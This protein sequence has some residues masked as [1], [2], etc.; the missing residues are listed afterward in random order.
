MRRNMT[1][2]A[3]LLSLFV[4][5]HALYSRDWAACPEDIGCCP[6]VKAPENAAQRANPPQVG[7]PYGNDR[8]TRPYLAPFAHESRYQFGQ[9]FTFGY[10]AVESIPERKKSRHNRQ[11]RLSR[12]ER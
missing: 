1:Y 6:T 8:S 12:Q 5:T 2:V 10:V 9:P 11:P 3:S 4:L 7:Y